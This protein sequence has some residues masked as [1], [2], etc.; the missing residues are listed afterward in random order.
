MNLLYKT[1]R[2]T[3]F[4]YER[5]KLPLIEVIEYLKHEQ[6]NIFNDVNIILFVTKGEI[7]VSVGKHI[8]KPVT[9]NK[10]CFIPAQHPCTALAKKNSEVLIFR[11]NINLEF[12]DHFSFEMLLDGNKRKLKETIEFTALKITS[13]MED[14]IE[15]IKIYLEEGIKCSFFLTIKQKELLFLLK[16]Y[17]TK[18][19]LYSFFTPILST[20]IQF[21]N[22]VYKYYKRIKSVPQLAELMNYSTSGFEKKFKKVFGFPVYQWMKKQ[23]AQ[24][25]YHEINCT[26]KT[27]SEIGYEY[28]FSSSAYFCSF[29]KM[30]FGKTPGKIRNYSGKT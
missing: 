1:E 22:K 24:S 7:T 18:E 8:N 19:A 23:R 17:Y 9:K 16:T 11:L 6:L 15:L 10:F 30:N 21:S 26:K 25:V 28:G 4:S 5:D 27:F 12:C 14:Y 13:K 3:C 20:D 2:Q 29:C